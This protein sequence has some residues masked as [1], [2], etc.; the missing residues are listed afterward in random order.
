MRQHDRASGRN[1]E[2]SDRLEGLNEPP[3]PVHQQN[4]A[5]GQ[6]DQRTGC[7][8][9][10]PVVVSHT[11]HEERVDQ[12]RIACSMLDHGFDGKNRRRGEE[13]HRDQPPRCNPAEQDR[14][15][16]QR[17]AD[18]ARRYQGGMGDFDTDNPVGPAGPP[19]NQLAQAQHRAE[20]RDQDHR[21]SL[22]P[23]GKKCS[24]VRD[25]RRASR[26]YG[27]RICRQTK[28]LHVLFILSHNY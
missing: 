20:G 18:R 23:G 3:G 10:H 17:E 27:T 19:E 25:L 6:K 2:K 21:V 1:P 7:H 16:D 22:M 24:H 15:A 26:R 9:G 14:D 4:V 12:H 8:R 13:R 5:P 11:V 28:N